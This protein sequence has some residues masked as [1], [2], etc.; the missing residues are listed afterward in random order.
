MVL[1]L[2]SVFFL[3]IVVKKYRG[4]E[5]P[6]EMTGVWRYLTCAYQRKEFINTCPAEHEIEFAY[7]DVAK[8][9]K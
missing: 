7:L 1:S 5:I 6:A 3:Q 2:V 8:R 4:L 9:I